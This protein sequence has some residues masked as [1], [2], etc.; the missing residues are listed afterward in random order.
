MYMEKHVFVKEKNVYKWAKHGFATTS[1]SQINSSW[2]GN[3]LSRK[4][5]VL[6]IAVKNVILAVFW[7]MKVSITIDFLEK[8]STELSVGNIFGKIYFIYW[9]TL[10]KEFHFV[11][12]KLKLNKP[13]IN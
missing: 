8:G 5:K 1:R 2:S 9:M 7:D 11:E 12:C 10:T 3:S 4:E 13:S 6:Y